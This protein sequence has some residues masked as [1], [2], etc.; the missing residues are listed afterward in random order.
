MLGER[1]FERLIRY[2]LLTKLAPVCPQAYGARGG[3]ASSWTP[4]ALF[5][6]S[7]GSDRGKTPSG[8]SD[9]PGLEAAGTVAALGSGVTG[10]KVGWMCA[11]PPIAT[12]LARAHQ[13]LTFSTAPNL[14]WAVAEGLET[15]D[16]W[17]ADSIVGFQRSRDRLAAGLAK[18]VLVVGA[19][20]DRDPAATGGGPGRRRW[21]GCAQ[22]VGG[23]SH[24]HQAPWDSL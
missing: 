13:F 12:L 7:G 23:V 10:W 3:G 22:A 9:L 18:H 21:L 14:Q 24:A 20:I 2:T 8:A 1:K 11:A 15:Q 5:L 16:A 6:L 19:E 17:I 4:T